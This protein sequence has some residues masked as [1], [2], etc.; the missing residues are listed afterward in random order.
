LKFSQFASNVSG[1]PYP[2]PRCL[3]ACQLLAKIVHLGD[4][5]K[6]QC[7]RTNRVL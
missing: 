2:V 1:S 7:G 4:A 6:K 5:P 3:I